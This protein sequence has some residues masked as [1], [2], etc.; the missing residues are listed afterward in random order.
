VAGSDGAD[1]RDDVGAIQDVFRPAVAVVGTF[2]IA[3]VKVR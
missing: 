2:M 3:A 1:L